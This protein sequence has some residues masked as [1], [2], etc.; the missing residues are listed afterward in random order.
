MSFL[1]SISLL[2]LSATLATACQVPVFRYALERWE[3]D[4]YRLFVVTPKALDAAQTKLLTDFTKQS[5]HANLQLNILNTSKLTD[6]QLWKLPSIDTS[7]TSSQLALYP[8]TSH[9]NKSPIVTLPLTRENLNITLQSPIRKKIVK[10]IISGSSCV[11]LVLYQGD[12]KKA[13]SIQ[14]KLNTHLQKVE[15]TI[16]IPDGII[17]TEERHKIT[18]STDLEDV[19]R[20]SI[21]LKIAFT[22]LLIDRNDPAE[23]TFIATLLANSPPAIT[24]NGET[25]I[26]PIF[27]RGRQLPPMPASRLAYSSILNG[28][29]YLC[30]ACSCQVKEQN[31]GFDLL[32]N[33]NWP[34]H[35]T[36][37]LA[38][39]DKTLPPLEGAGDII[40]TKPTNPTSKT[41]S[42]QVSGTSAPQPI[43]ITRFIPWIIGG[44]VV[45]IILISLIVLKRES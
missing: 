28:C 41:T 7:V 40:P 43:S 31:P 4:S 39:I 10:H 27:G 20:S 23:K 30:G 29:Q 42:K 9:P 19:L 36:T 14:A 15:K 11:W 35:L 5:Q 26:I 16:H 1:K 22:S 38:V 37:G 6:A 17:G 34:S 18:D 8:P 24:Q 33:E 45:I 13:Q 3:S 32:I 25:L 44:A 21:P 2:I 12:L